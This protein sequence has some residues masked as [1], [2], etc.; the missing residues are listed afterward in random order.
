M[1]FR[2]LF[3]ATLFLLPLLAQMALAGGR[4]KRVLT[5]QDMVYAIVRC[6]Q[7]KDAYSY[8]KLFPSSDTMAAII[9][10]YAK[11]ESEE[12]QRMAWLRDHPEA[13]MHE[14]SVID[15]TLQ[16]DFDSLVKRG[17]E[18]LGIHWN[19]ILLARYE[20]MK[21]RET[22]DVLYERLAPTRFIGFIFIRDGLTQKTYGVCVADIMKI[23]EEWYGGQL[24]GV[25]RASTIDE[26]L[27]AEDAE[28]KGK[29]LNGENSD[30]VT[31]TDEEKKDEDNVPRTQKIIV[32]RKFYSGMFDNEIPVQLYI[33]YLKGSCPEVTCV[34]EAIYKFGD[35][36]DY[37]KLNVSRTADGKWIFTEDPPQGVMEL[38]LDKD[39][40]TGTW[41]ATDNQTGYD[42]KLTEITATPKKTKQLDEVI[43]KQLFAK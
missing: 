10:Q 13:A 3:I 17:E 6:L 12:Y 41:T 23:Q 14:D 2:S 26:Y 30:A 9:M 18:K 25:Y 31:V 37:I 39:H 4:H 8:M 22:R 27:K 7:Q 28:Q 15:A 40:Y 5:E 21:M 20:L 34:W 11:K 29:P 42:V 24:R 35:Q 19:N 38:K 33:R 32:E 1:R 16:Y 36:D 43:E